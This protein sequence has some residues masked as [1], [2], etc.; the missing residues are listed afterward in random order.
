M[1]K[2]RIFAIVFS[3]FSTLVIATGF[4]SDSKS[5]ATGSVNDD[6]VEMPN[7]QPYVIT[8]FDYFGGRFQ[9]VA[10]AT[11][12]S[13]KE[14]ARCVSTKCPSGVGGD[15]VIMPNNQPYVI[16]CVSWN[17]TR[18]QTYAYATGCS[19]LVNATCISTTCP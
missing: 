11:G 14:Q 6:V 9:K 17:G 5:P 15:G 19:P 7:H 16:R 13:P 3:S 8:C 18:L 4:K 10:F 2:L 12:C 1:R